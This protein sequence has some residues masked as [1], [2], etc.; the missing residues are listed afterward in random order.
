MTPF[1]FNS[2]SERGLIIEL[3]DRRA[4]MVMRLA[5]FFGI[6]GVCSSPVMRTIH[7]IGRRMAQKL[8][9]A[10]FTA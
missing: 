7:P 8:H 2:E 4:S 10:Y 6:R 3:E 9:H 5:G 1:R